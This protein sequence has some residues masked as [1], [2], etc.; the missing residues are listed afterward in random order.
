MHPRLV[1]NNDSVYVKAA[2]K[3][4]QRDGCL[5]LVRGATNSVTDVFTIKEANL[6]HTCKINLVQHESKRMGQWIVGEIISD[7]VRSKPTVGAI[8]LQYEL[9]KYWHG[10]EVARSELFGTY[11][12][13]FDE[14]RWYTDGIHRTNPGSVVCLENEPNENRFQRYFVA[15]NASLQGFKHYRPM[16]FIDGTFMKTKYKGTLLSAITK[17]GNNGKSRPHS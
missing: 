10:V 6:L 2:C 13:S 9:L 7:A 5:W 15:F 16:L 4:R 3:Y 1:S 14:L 11:E 12:N 8:T 17:D